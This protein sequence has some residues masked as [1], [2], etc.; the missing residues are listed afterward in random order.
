MLVA[1]RTSDTRDPLPTAAERKFLKKIFQQ[2]TVNKRNL[3]VSSTLYYFNLYRRAIGS[4][5]SGGMTSQEHDST[6]KMSENDEGLQPDPNFCLVEGLPLPIFRPTTEEWQK[7]ITDLRNMELRHDD[8]LLC[9][10]PKSG[11][12]WLW[13]VTS[14]LV[15]GKAE[16]ETRRQE[17]LMVDFVDVD[18][19]EAM[20]SPRILNTH[21]PFSM[22]PWQQIRDKSIKVFHVYRNPKDTAVS[23][24][25]MMKEFIKARRNVLLEFPDFFERYLNGKINYGS[26]FSYLR[27]FHDFTQEN[28][29]IPAL[30]I[31]YEDMKR[32]P[33]DKIKQIAEFLEV[34]ASQ[35]L[36]EEIAEAC[37]FQNM[38]KQDVNKAVIEFTK[39]KNIPHPKLN[40]YR[41]G[42]VG[43]WKNYLTVAMSEQMDAVVEKELKDLPYVIQYL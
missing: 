17:Q 30:S 39:Q 21:L 11:T 18:L 26:Q 38:K 42:E 37:S 2:Q 3:K 5:S 24:Y 13:E 6:F 33:S 36:C 10:Y 23:F 8:I 14:M 43:D 22:L 4:I 9:T 16:Y 34:P 40:M 20:A 15:Q 32:S 1:H 12:H 27:Q 35:Q 25:F 19:I 29:N 7:H 28:P 31:S 41:K